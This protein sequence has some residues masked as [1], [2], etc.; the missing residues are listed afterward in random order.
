MEVIYK[1]PAK[2]S[3]VPQKCP[4]NPPFG[5]APTID[6]QPVPFTDYTVSYQK[7]DW[8]GF[9]HNFFWGGHDNNKDLKRR[10]FAADAKM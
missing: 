4:A 10:A 9:F 8:Q 1:T 7:K 6:L 2:M 3:Q 5:K